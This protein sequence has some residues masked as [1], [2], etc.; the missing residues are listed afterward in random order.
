MRIGV[1]LF[2]I[3]EGETGGLVPLLQGVLEALFAGWPEHEVV[4]FGTPDN[5]HLFPT[6]PSQ[7]CRLTLPP[8]ASFFPLLDVH[9]CHLGLDVLVC[10][11]PFEAELTFPRARQVVVI[12]DCQHEFFPDF[13]SLEML[14]ERC[15]SFAKAR[16]GAGAIA[17]LSEHARQTLLNHPSARCRDV[18]IMSPAL[19]AEW[20]HP[21]LENLREVE[22]ALLPSGDFFLFPANLWAHKNH[23][24]LLQAFA[25]FLQ[26]VGRPVELVFT[27][28]PQGWEEVAR[29]FPDLPVRH[30]GFVRRG[31]LQVL[32]ARARA[33]TFFSLFEGF[34]MPLLEAFAVGTP[35]V[36]SNTTSLPEVGGE[37]VL[38]CDPTDPVAMSETMVRV[39]TE[40]PLRDRLAACGQE[41]LTLFSWHASAAH[42]VNACAR[43]HERA[44]VVVDDPLPALQRLNRLVQEIEEDRAAKQTTIEQLDAACT[45]RLEAIQ[46]LDAACTARLEAIQ[47][48][49]AA[50]RQCKADLRESEADRAAKGEVIHRLDAALREPLIRRFL[51][52]CKLRNDK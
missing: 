43:V 45:A 18:F 17:T 9:A 12:P 44:P 33:L 48:L 36:C 4:L 42:L 31:F 16:E 3:I 19:W 38:T 25:L 21:S 29:S 14:R 40:E 32:L 37:A 26:K 10:S 39:F 30:L 35:V 8:T 47:Q 11:Y 51:R 7:V 41:R 20:E 34:G 27:G 22:H 1:E 46:Q 28:H 6:L 5:E 15:R 50:L 49:D 2:N 13:F 23:R 52:L 24:R